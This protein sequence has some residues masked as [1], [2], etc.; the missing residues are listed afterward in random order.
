ME[1]EDLVNILTIINPKIVR[2][3]KFYYCEYM[4]NSVIQQIANFWGLETFL[5]T[6]GSGIDKGV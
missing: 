6:K 5:F 2:K 4:P 1:H 3:L